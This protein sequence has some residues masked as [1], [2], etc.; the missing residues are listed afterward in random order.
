LALGFNLGDERLY[1]VEKKWMR[2]EGPA[3]DDER[4]AAHSSSADK[5]ASRSTL[6]APTSECRRSLKPASRSCSRAGCSAMS[7]ARKP[8]KASS[9]G[10]VE[11]AASATRVSTT[12]PSGR[13]A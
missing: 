5:G 10:S 9:A 1:R 7:L 2:E 12:L 11:A 8:R 3:V 4:R 13:M 6:M